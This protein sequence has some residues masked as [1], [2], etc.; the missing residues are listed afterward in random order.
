MKKV[1]FFMFLAVVSLV[2]KPYSLPGKCHYMYTKS[3]DNMGKSDMYCFVQYGAVI[4]NK[5]TPI[6]YDNVMRQDDAVPHKSS[7]DIN[8][9]ILN[10]KKFTKKAYRYFNK[11]MSKKLCHE[12]IFKFFFKHGFKYINK[13]YTK[14]G[15]LKY[16]YTI[17]N[18]TCNNL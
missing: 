2:A 6:N 12:K 3:V 16:T 1:L 17:T 7:I 14:K 13:F 4:M 5:N 8:Y 10:S 9:T 11:E 15:K 18:K